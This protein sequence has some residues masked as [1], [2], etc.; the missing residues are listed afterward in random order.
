M[1]HRRVAVQVVMT[2]QLACEQPVRLLLGPHMSISHTFKSCQERQL[3]GGPQS[4]G[5]LKQALSLQNGNQFYE[6]CCIVHCRTSCLMMHNPQQQSQTRRLGWVDQ[7]QYILL[8]IATVW[9]QTRDR[10]AVCLLPANSY[11]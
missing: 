9:L 6:S 3:W 10:L 4:Q 7:G 2:Y 1:P 11:S 5:R 8:G